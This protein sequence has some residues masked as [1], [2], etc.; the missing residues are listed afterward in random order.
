M[1]AAR[2]HTLTAGMLTAAATRYLRRLP[3]A[4]GRLTK[5]PRSRTPCSTAW[6][7][8]FLGDAGVRRDARRALAAIDPALLL[9]NAAAA[10]PSS[11]ARS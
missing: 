10:G 1:I 5:R 3:L 11:T 4:Y 8:P 2:T 7:R 6:V 9:D